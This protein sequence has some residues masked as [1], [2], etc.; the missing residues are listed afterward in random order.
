[1]KLQWTYKRDVGNVFNISWR[2]V[3]G[4]GAPPNMNTIGP[5]GAALLGNEESRRSRAVKGTL[6]MVVSATS[7]GST[8]NHG[9]S[10]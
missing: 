6:N 4:G 7:I 9:P 2:R 10:H 3:E 8:K 1:M 5:R